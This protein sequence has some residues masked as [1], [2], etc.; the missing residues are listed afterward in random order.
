MTFAGEKECD[1]SQPANG[2]G[3]LSAEC[4]KARRV[5]VSC[6]KLKKL[7]CTHVVK[8]NRLYQPHAAGAAGPWRC[9]AVLVALSSGAASKWW[10][11]KPSRQ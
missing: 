6:L 3:A 4:G 5:Y 9:A 8:V 10:L 2:L 1:P 11:V 7:R